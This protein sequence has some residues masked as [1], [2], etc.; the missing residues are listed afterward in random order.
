MLNKLV[1]MFN[2]GQDGHR[3]GPRVAMEDEH[4]R[5]LLSAL[6]AF[7]GSLRFKVPGLAVSD[8]FFVAPFPLATVLAIRMQ[9]QIPG[10]GFEAWGYLGRRVVEFSA[11]PQSYSQRGERE[12]RR[13]SHAFWIPGDSKLSF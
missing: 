6:R 13:Q 4:R 11:I 5:R 12:S 8:A 10:S 3:I 9:F 1:E 7:G 2:H